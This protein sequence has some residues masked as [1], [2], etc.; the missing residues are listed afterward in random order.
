VAVAAVAVGAV[1]CAWLL[2]SAITN[3]LADR[4]ASGDRT[5]GSVATV[6]APV[7]APVPTPAPTAAPRPT[8]PANGSTPRMSAPTEV[9]AVDRPVPSL[10][11]GG[12]H[13]VKFEVWA[14]GEATVDIILNTDE[15]YER[16]YDGVDLPWAAEAD[17][18]SRI[19]ILSIEA[20]AD[21]RRDT[22]LACR[23][24]LDGVVV[25]EQVGLSWAGCWINVE[26]T[27]NK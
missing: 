11:S 19:E 2:V 12:P 6:P 20:Y 9:P 10:P 25:S 5:A 15:A 18:D 24:S 8:T 14:S 7:P 21:S 27:Y 22:P 4:T 1:V 16:S 17:V 26:G 23:I 13:R 3:R